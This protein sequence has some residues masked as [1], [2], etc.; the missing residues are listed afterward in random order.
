MTLQ[1]VKETITLTRYKN[2]INDEEWERTKKSLTPFNYRDKL[3]EW[4]NKVAIV[5]CVKS[6]LVFL[7]QNLRRAHKRENPYEI[8][9]DLDYLFDIGEKQNWK[10]ALSGEPLEFTRGGNWIDNTNPNSCT[11]D[12]IN[13]DF[14]YVPDNI[15]LLSW[16]VNRLK[17]D[18]SQEELL[19]IVN[20]IYKTK[21][22]NTTQT[23]V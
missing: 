6:K 23:I 19:A 12:R 10:C 4:E 18:Y 2:L 21:L 14:G 1:K 3:S 11:I 7:S 20:S 9:V 13:S 16:R 17:R 15:Q 8:T 22:D 5:E